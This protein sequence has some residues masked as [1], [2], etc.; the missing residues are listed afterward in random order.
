MDRFYGTSR[1]IQLNGNLVNPVDGCRS[2]FKRFNSGSSLWKV[3]VFDFEGRQMEKFRT[4][5]YGHEPATDRPESQVG[6]QNKIPY[7]FLVGM[8]WAPGQRRASW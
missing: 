1:A 6:N 2:P 5:I 3:V 7:G 4:L 8:R